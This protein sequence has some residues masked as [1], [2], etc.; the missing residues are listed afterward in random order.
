M[1]S[2]TF[3]QGQWYP[4]SWV[5][6]VNGAPELLPEGERG[7]WPADLNGGPPGGSETPSEASEPGND[8]EPLEA[9]EV[10]HEKPEPIVETSETKPE[11]RT[12]ILHRKGA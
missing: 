12:S 9:G 10:I 8:P 3:V 5:K 6:V 11:S 4:W 2:G 7:D 1:S